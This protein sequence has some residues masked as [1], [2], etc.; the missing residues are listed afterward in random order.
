MKKKRKTQ[1]NWL[2]TGKYAVLTAILL[3]AVT[4]LG[5]TYHT[6]DQYV[7]IRV[8][9]G[10]TIWQIA[11]VAADNKNDVRSVVNDIIETNHLNH[12]QQIYP[13]QTLQIPVTASRA[14]T[15]RQT[16]AAP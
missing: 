1:K 16:F 13:G 8:Q 2:K 4:Q 12:D 3:L 15:V 11:S 5:M 10:D 6:N 14:D 7:P 9:N